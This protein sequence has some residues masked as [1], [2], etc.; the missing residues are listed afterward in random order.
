MDIGAEIRMAES[1]PQKLKQLY[2]TARRKGEVAVFRSALLRC[3]ETGSG[4]LL[5][6]T[7]FHRRQ[8]A[9]E[10]PPAPGRVRG[11]EGRLP[12]HRGVAPA[13][14]ADKTLSTRPRLAATLGNHHRPGSPRRR[15]HRAGIGLRGKVGA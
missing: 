15:A 4:N 2:Q 14:A 11:P 3:Y 1:S 5:V 6:E 13:G 12:R 9:A 8:Q 7:W 10:A